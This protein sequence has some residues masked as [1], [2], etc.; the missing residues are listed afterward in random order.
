MTVSDL[1]PSQE[2]DSIAVLFHGFQICRYAAKQ[3]S[4]KRRRRLQILRTILAEVQ[5]RDTF[6][7]P[8]EAPILNELSQVRG[9]I[10]DPHAKRSPHAG[11]S[12][13]QRELLSFVQILIAE[14]ER[15][16]EGGS[17]EAVRAFGDQFHNFPGGLYEDRPV[18]RVE[19]KHFLQLAAAFWDELSSDMRD[20]F[21]K[22]AGVD[23]VTADRLV[24]SDGF[25]VPRGW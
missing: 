15:L 21:S 25:A 19:G 4:P 8:V 12:V 18:N 22:L 2:I 7:V 23:P 14:L 1:P 13:N 10:A 5:H 6:V 20:A 3:E 16:A 24:R 11:L 17:L 9:A